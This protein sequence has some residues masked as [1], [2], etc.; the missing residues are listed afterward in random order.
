MHKPNLHKYAF[1]IIPLLFLLY[2]APGAL[3][4]LFHHPDEKY[5][6]DA[7]LQMMEKED[8]FT[9]YQA[10]GAPRFKKPII[11]YWVVMASYKLFGVSRFSSRVFFWLAGALLVAV[12]YL[13]A[14]SVSENRKVATTAAFI[15][16]ANPLVLMSSSRSIPDILLVLF[17]M[18]SAW[19]FLKLMLADRIRKRYYWMAYVGAALAF[20]VKGL[21][22]AAFAGASMLYLLFNPWRK[23]KWQQLIEPVSMI[24]AV[25]VALSWFAVVYAKHGALFWESFFADQVGERVSSKILKIFENIIVALGFL[26]AFLVPWI[27]ILFS[28]TKSMVAY[29]RQS[30]SKEKALFGFVFTWVVFMIIMSGAVS[31]F[32]DRYLLPVLPLVS[33]FIAFVIVNSKTA[34][35]KTILKIFLVFGLGIFTI[36]IWYAVFI[37]PDPVLIAGAI[38]AGALYALYFAGVF[39][40]LQ[41]EVKIANAFMLFYFGVFVLLYPLL[42][43]NPG[44][45]LVDNLKKQGLTDSDKVYVYGNIRTA[46][47]I[48]IHG[49]NGFEVV[50]KDTNFILPEEPVH[51][52]VVKEK[53]MDLLDL[54]GYDVFPG[55]EEWLRVP[56]DRFP[57]VLKDPVADLKENGT[58]YFIAKPKEQHRVRSEKQE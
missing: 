23:L 54:Q 37:L 31:K 42:M 52:L 45:Q 17:L 13:M 21:P 2:S 8:C 12:T 20:E 29:L 4:F 7:V 47:N 25:L 49:R 33:V 36:N 58:K 56:V 11:T 28:K 30:A 50:S 55:S 43:P 38:V 48:R 5:Y 16:A 19:G 46:S 10:D 41:D 53:E 32:Y 34:F 3:D 9:P 24:V 44:R 26:V 18:V 35:R 27:F 57:E 15:T 1:L 39:R 14:L 51:F 40:R 22:A 6:T